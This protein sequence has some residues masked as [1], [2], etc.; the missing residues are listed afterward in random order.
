[1]NVGDGGTRFPRAPAIATSL[2]SIVCAVTAAGAAGTTQPAPSPVQAMRVAPAPADSELLTRRSPGETAGA[3]KPVATPKAPTSSYDLPRVLLALGIVIALI[4]VLRWLGRWMF[5][6]NVAQRSTRAIQVVSRSMVSPKQQ[7]LLVQVG[8]R[9]VLVGDAGTQMNPLC[10]IS[11]PDEVAALL[12]QI[13]AEKGELVT[14]AFGSIF[15]RAKEKFDAAQGPT[16][17]EE[18]S[19]R[20]AG[21]V[22]LT[23]GDDA[24]PARTSG[25]DD[26]NDIE[27]LMTKVRSLSRQF[28]R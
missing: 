14:K 23:V 20:V 28:N 19:L 1:M 10:E 22:D 4:F 27:G 5:G 7:L 17:S 3:A 8:N 13:R 24:S 12:G 21:T 25:R 15:G 11:D 2:L 9:L 16:A 26:R 18:E 6:G